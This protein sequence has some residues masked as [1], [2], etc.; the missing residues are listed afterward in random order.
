[1]H[2]VLP[3]CSGAEIAGRANNV[4]EVQDCR[5]ICRARPHGLEPTGDELR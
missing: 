1:M 3:T 5:S 2:I 4:L